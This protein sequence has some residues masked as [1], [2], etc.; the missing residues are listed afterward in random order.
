M[1]L[2]PLVTAG[3][4]NLL[5]TFLYRS[6]ALKSART[7]LQGKVLRVDLKGFSTSLVWCLVSARSMCWGRGKAK[8]IAP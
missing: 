8:P 7:R 5:N 1:P 3:V 4:E 6:P 2:K